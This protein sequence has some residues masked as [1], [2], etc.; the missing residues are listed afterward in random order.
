MSD[1]PAPKKQN[2][3][4]HTEMRRAAR[5]FALQAIYQWEM[6]GNA[7]SDIELQFRMDNDMTG[8]DL[9]LFNELLHGVPANVAELD[10]AYEPFLDRALDDLDPI[11]RAVLR[12]GSFELIYR[13]VVP[14]K[15]VINESVDLAKIFGATESHKYVNGILDKLAARVRM[16]EINAK[17]GK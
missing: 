8:T 3:K 7:V 1:T 11:E 13:I 14:Y 17:R 2:K 5:S 6:S 10:R 12:I 4:S 9:S 15:V 16:T